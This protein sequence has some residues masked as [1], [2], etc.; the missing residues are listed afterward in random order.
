MAGR[1]P[2]RRKRGLTKIGD[3]TYSHWDGATETIY[4]PDTITT[5]FPEFAEA[6]KEFAAEL[7]YPSANAFIICAVFTIDQEANNQKRYQ[8]YRHLATAAGFR[9]R[10][11]FPDYLEKAVKDT[12]STV[13]EEFVGFRA[14]D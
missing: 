2:N 1:A 11:K 10:T 8:I 3:Y 13:G 4:D 6:C 12:W 9:G 7:G 5:M 14:L